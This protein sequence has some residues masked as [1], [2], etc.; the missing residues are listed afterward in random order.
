[1]ID[2]RKTVKQYSND[3]S[4]ELYY[5]IHQ[6]AGVNDVRIKM[7]KTIKSQIWRT[8]TKNKSAD[9]AVDFLSRFF[10]FSFAVHK[11]QHTIYLCCSCIECYQQTAHRSIQEWLT[12]LGK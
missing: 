2:D 3:S 1:M 5:Q 10:F 9:F 12:L 8:A 11:T 4:C 6:P 7:N